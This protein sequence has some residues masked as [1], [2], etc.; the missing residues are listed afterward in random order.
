MRFTVV[1]DVDDNVL[2][3]ANLRMLVNVAHSFGTQA[4]LELEKEILTKAEELRN[5]QRSLNKKEKK[6]DGTK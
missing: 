4:G 1:Q 2:E 6:K 3:N 5:M